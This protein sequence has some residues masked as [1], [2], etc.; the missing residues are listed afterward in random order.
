VIACA[1]RMLGILNAMLRDELSWQDT[2][3][4][5]GHVLPQTA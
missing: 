2:D 5:R 4:G 1:R 3:V